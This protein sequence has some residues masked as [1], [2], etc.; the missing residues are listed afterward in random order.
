MK[1]IC[2][3]TIFLFFVL[4]FAFLAVLAAEK[5][6]SV[7][8]LDG[9]APYTLLKENATIGKTEIVPPGKDSDTLQGYSWDI[10]RECFH[11]QGWTIELTVI[12][13]ARAMNKFEKGE[14]EVLFPTGKNKERLL[15]Y[16]YSV[17]PINQVS[18]QIYV[19]QDSSMEWNGLTSLMGK[20]IG[21]R[22]NFNL[23]DRWNQSAEKLNLYEIDS[24]EQ[25]FQMLQANRIDGFAGYDINWDF[26]LKNS[27]KFQ[28]GSFKK[29]PPFGKT[30]EFVTTL[31]TNPRSEEILT[32]FDAGFERIIENGV[33]SSIKEKWLGQ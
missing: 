22:R 8:T 7:T 5:T 26:F 17:N 29:L 21:V 31:K 27:E 30:E 2:K 9:Y 33:L 32:A 11:S 18:F 19:N 13:W 23:G 10:L 16:D 1:V 14:V 25:G 28:S 3:K 24:T 20:K 4:F 15:L 12:P 6:V